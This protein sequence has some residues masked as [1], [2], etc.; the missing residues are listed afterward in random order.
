MKGSIRK[1]KTPAGKTVYIKLCKCGREIRVRNDYAKIHSGKCRS[2]SRKGRPYETNYKNLFHDW[3]N[4]KVTLS[5][6]EYLS[7]TEIK[8]CHYC[9]S[10]IPWQTNRSYTKPQQAY[11][12]DRKDNNGPY[13]KDNC[14]VCC[15]RCNRMR[16]NKF[17]YEEFLL[18][19]PALITIENAR[20]SK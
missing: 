8:N 3:R 7:F 19:R 9:Y 12:L 17:S 18:F 11:F 10:Q 4:T 15:T 20:R 14:V 13:S 16:S 1:E 5:Y 6:E 2:C